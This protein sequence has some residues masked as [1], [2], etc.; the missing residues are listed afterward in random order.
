MECRQAVDGKLHFLRNARIVL[1]LEVGV[2]PPGMLAKQAGAI[3][4]EQM[5][6][7]VYRE[8]LER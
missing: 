8:L 7:I 2:R 5:H 6:G 3:A 4:L 1:V